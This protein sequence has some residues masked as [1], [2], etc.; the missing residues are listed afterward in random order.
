MVGREGKPGLCK[1]WE[2]SFLEKLPGCSHEH[3]TGCISCSGRGTCSSSREGLFFSLSSTLHPHPLFLGMLSGCLRHLTF[4][5]ANISNKAYAKETLGRQ[6]FFFLLSKCTVG[7]DLGRQP[8]T[9][10]LSPLFTFSLFSCS[11]VTTFN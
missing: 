10:V 8:F 4:A 11:L 9:P 2:V 7:W 1:G 6:I 5:R 3:R